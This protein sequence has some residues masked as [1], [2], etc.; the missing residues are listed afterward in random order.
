MTITGHNLRRAY[1]R[2]EAENQASAMKDWLSLAAIG[3][4]V[5]VLLA[6]VG[7]M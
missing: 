3:G 6:Y 7:A 2:A 5:L 4:F 1:I